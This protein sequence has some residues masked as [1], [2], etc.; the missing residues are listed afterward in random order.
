M[1]VA[2]EL[3]D[4]V[5]FKFTPMLDPDGCATG[6]VRFNANGY[7]VNRHW[8]EVDLRRKEF[9]ERM[10][11]IWYAKKAILAHVESGRPIDL[12][13]NLHNTET[14][15]YIDT[16]ASEDVT[17]ALMSRFFDNLVSST[18]FDPS[19]PLRFADRPDHTTNSLYH[20]R[21]IPVDAHGAADLHEQEAGAAV[22]GGGSAGVRE[23]A[24]H[25]H[26]PDRPAID[27]GE[28]PAIIAPPSAR[29]YHERK[30]SSTGEPP[31]GVRTPCDPGGHRHE[32]DF[33]TTDDFPPQPPPAATK[34]LPGTRNRKTF[35]ARPASSIATR[36]MGFAAAPKRGTRHAAASD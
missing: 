35:P 20:E 18:T 16:Q 14:A 34:A 12:M 24:H 10:P 5:V 23:A 13:L 7:D 4:K 6:K 3:R 25:G 36:S 28:T 15:E 26:G 29:S 33:P 27:P 11:E 31:I 2:R 30:K 21:K 17:R 8:D 9:L 19:Q 22:D 1:P 32:N